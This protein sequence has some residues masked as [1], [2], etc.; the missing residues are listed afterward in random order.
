MTETNLPEGIELIPTP[1]PP[2]LPKLVRHRGDRR[3]FAVYYEGTHA[4]WSDG[5]AGATFSFYHVYQ[6]LTEHPAVALYL[7]ERDLGS[8]DGPPRDALL[9]DR[10][11]GRLYVGSAEAV[12]RVLE[13]QHPP[14]PR[15]PLTREEFEAAL[16]EMEEEWRQAAETGNWAEAGMFEWLARPSPAL[17]AGRR[18]LLAWLD[19]HIT[20]QVVRRYLALLDAGDFRAYGPLRYIHDRLEEAR[21]R[22]QA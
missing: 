5:R 21:R 22:Q 2:G 15:A 18:G 1:M 3:Y 20:E 4:T 10:E 12:R 16:R 6:P 19:R 17:E 11:R 13:E 7:W 14:H 8:D 9:V